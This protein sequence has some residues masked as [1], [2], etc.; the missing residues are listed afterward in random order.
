MLPKFFILLFCLFI[1]LSSQAVF[2]DEK[3]E[4]LL[5]TVEDRMKK[6]KVLSGEYET[7]RRR[8]EPIEEIRERGQFR[9]L[10]PNYISI[11]GANFLPSKTVGK[12]DKISDATGYVSNGENFYTLY[13]RP[14][15]LFY[16]EA[17]AD[18]TGKNVSFE[19][20]P[21]ADFFDETKSLL[22]QILEARRKNQL[23]TLRYAGKQIWENQ[24]FDVV[25][26]V[27]NDSV[28]GTARRRITEI[29]IGA[30]EIVHRLTVNEKIGELGLQADTV[31]RNVV[32]QSNASPSDFAYVLPAT[33][34]IYIPPPAPLAN[35]AIAPDFTFIDKTGVPVKLSDFRGKTVVLDFWAT[36]CVPCLK[37][38]PHTDEVVKKFKDGSVVVLAV[39]IWDGAENRKNWLARNNDR[40]QSFTFVID[41]ENA[42]QN[43]ST[44]AFQVGTLPLQYVISPSGKVVSSLTGYFGPNDRLEE[45][46]KSADKF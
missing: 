6:I 13:S 12:F 23:T 11:K 7:I 44:T 35:G 21:I 37:S 34:K 45:A 24:S 14:E 8:L 19:L 40:F 42:G 30:D 5:K 3:A 16:K 18:Q 9:L 36:W 15:G 32:L 41:A 29:F 10:K 27:T 4:K 46:L 26:F 25:E 22:N 43:N 28:E 38:F 17:R 33:A 31:L 39:N 1:F 2:A 20:P